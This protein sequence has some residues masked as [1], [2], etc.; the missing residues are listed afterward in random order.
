V[1]KNQKRTLTDP[2]ADAPVLTMRINYDYV[3]GRQVQEEDDND[4]D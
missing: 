1:K 3:N 4:D 2:N